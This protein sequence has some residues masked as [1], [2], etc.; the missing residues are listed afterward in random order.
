MAPQQLQRPSVRQV[1]DQLQ[2]EEVEGLLDSIAAQAGV[3]ERMTTREAERPTN[4]RQME[5]SEDNLLETSFSSI[6]VGSES[7]AA[8]RQT[9]ELSSVKTNNT[10]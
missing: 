1:E 7:L 8:C 9:M 4:L 6:P 2:L 3:E 5:L 10:Q